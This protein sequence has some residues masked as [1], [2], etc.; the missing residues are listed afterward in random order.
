MWRRRPRGDEAAPRAGGDRPGRWRSGA[1]AARRSSGGGAPGARRPAGRSRPG[2]WP[3]PRPRRS[4]VTSR[5]WW[6]AAR[7]RTVSSSRTVSPASRPM[8]GLVEHEGQPLTGRPDVAEGDDPLDQQPGRVGQRALLAGQVGGQERRRLLAALGERHDGRPVVERPV[9]RRAAGEQPPL[10]GHRVVSGSRVQQ[11]APALLVGERAGA[12]A[13]RLVGG[14]AQRR[15]AGGVRGGARPARP[16]G[17]TAPAAGPARPAR[18]APSPSSGCRRGTGRR[19]PAAGARRR[20]GAGDDR[21]EDQ[22]APVRLGGG[23]RAGARLGRQLERLRGADGRPSPSRPPRRAGPPAPVA[24]TTAALRRASAAAS[25]L[26]R[27]PQVAL[28]EGGEV[29]GEAVVVGPAAAFELVRRR[30]RSSP[31]ARSAASTPMRPRR[32]TRPIRRAR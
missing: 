2:G 7:R 6:N 18:G 28:V 32:S 26:G 20:A 1:S 19:R 12:G 31:A 16:A 3:T 5:I 13:H 14:G 8:N 15:R 17:P 4:P 21:A 22:H 29:P 23:L 24:V 10:R 9:Q 30:H 27:R 25:L 11:Q